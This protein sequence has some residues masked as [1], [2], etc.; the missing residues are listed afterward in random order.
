M[1]G[2]RAGKNGGGAGTEE[3]VGDVEF[4]SGEH[5]FLLAEEIALEVS[6]FQRGEFH[7]ELLSFA[8]RHNA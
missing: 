4:C 3:R 5:I 1:E 8:H 7:F 2:P 6:N